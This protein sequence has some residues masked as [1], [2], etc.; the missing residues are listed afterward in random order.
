MNG[1]ISSPYEHIFNSSSVKSKNCKLNKIDPKVKIA[2]TFP[3]AC[4]CLLITRTTKPSPSADD[5]SASASGQRRL[6]LRSSVEDTD[7]VSY[8]ALQ[9]LPPPPFTLFTELTT[10]PIAAASLGQELR[11]G[12]LTFSSVCRF[13]VKEVAVMEAY[14]ELATKGK[15]RSD[16]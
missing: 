6:C 11:I 14:T 12:S 1:P 3:F 9:P 13:R 7:E 10:S 8:S 15:E 4:T 5:A 2:I 16:V